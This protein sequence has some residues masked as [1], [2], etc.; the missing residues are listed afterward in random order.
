V[1]Q[2]QLSVAGTTLASSHDVPTLSHHPAGMKN[3][4]FGTFLLVLLGRAL[5][6]SLV[7]PLLTLTGALLVGP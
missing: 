1:S 5:L 7:I 3:A 6:L 2:N 4:E